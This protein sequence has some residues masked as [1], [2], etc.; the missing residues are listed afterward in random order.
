MRDL[1][2]PGEF[3]LE[4]PLWGYLK[5]PLCVLGRHFEDLLPKEQVAGTFQISGF[6]IPSEI[7]FPHITAQC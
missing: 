6:M 5:V 7:L 3:Y 4:S 2:R 1:V